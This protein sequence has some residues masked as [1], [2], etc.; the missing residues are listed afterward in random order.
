MRETGILG[1]VDDLP[2]GQVMWVVDHP[3]VEYLEDLVGALAVPQGIA[4]DAPQGLMG[5]D[6]V[7]HQAAT[8][9][10]PRGADAVVEG[11]GDRDPPARPRRAARARHRPGPAARSRCIDGDG[12]ESVAEAERG[13]MTS[14]RSSSS[15][16]GTRIVW[17]T[18]SCSGAG[19]WS[20]FAFHRAL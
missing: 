12:S 15:G 18:R 4:G 6:L 9:G 17:P 20:L 2:R 10:N 19:T 8:L 13:G 5:A 11:V 16:G 3:A 14:E 1:E 7:D